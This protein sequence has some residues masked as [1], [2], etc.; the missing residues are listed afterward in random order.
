MTVVAS[1]TETSNVPASG[2]SMRSTALPVGSSR[3]VPGAA[4]IEEVEADAR[5]RPRH[6][7][8]GEI[9]VDPRPAALDGETGVD[10]L[11]RVG[12]VD[13]HQRLA[14]AHPT[15][16]SS[17]ANGPTAEVRLPQLLV[18][19]ATGLSTASCTNV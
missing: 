10:H 9:A 6:A 8:N 5:A 4:R 7:G 18:Q 2:T 11:L 13:A 14:I 12:L 16:P 17:T 15:S 19:S 1:T 3:P